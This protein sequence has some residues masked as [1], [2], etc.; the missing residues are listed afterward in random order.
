MRLPTAAEDND[1]DVQMAPL[2]D[3]VF[4]LLIF[5]LVATTLKKID[6]ELPVELPEAKAAVEVPTP[7]DLLVIAIDQHGLLHLGADPVPLAFL[8]DSIRQAAL[9]DPFQSVRLDIDQRTPM[10]FFVQVYDLCQLEGLRN[11]RLR[12]ASQQE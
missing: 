7:E 5:F 9:T 1:A 11:V 8:H 2:I 6:N 10:R 12:I 3:C 4:L